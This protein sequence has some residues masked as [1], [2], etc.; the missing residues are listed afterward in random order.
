MFKTPAPVNC[1]ANTRIQQTQ[2]SETDRQT[3]TAV[4]TTLM[5][6]QK[7]AKQ[8][9][10]E[11]RAHTP[12]TPPPPSEAAAYQLRHRILGKRWRRPQATGRRVNA[13]SWEGGGEAQ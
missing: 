10:H 13:G 3:D 8:V 5:K 11:T 4:A 9:N 7:I 6:E 1:N 12:H 2:T